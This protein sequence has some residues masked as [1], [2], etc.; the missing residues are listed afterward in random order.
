MNQKN[1]FL[2]LG[3]NLGDRATNLQLGVECIQNLIGV[4]NTKS[5]IYETAAWGNPDQSHFLN[6]AIKL[7]SAL[8]PTDFLS[9]ILEIE[10]SIG[11]TRDKKWEAR[12]IDID[13]IYF[14]NEIIETEALIVPHPHMAERKF[15]LIPLVEISPEFIN[16]K[17]KK[18]NAD[19]LKECK[20]DL[21]VQEFTN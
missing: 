4:I 3:S 9:K 2:L 12:I 10:K 19:L 1:I 16:P 13:I 17:L 11:R 20:D 21:L 18:S 14:G 8:S 6:Q 5:K 7:E 15:V